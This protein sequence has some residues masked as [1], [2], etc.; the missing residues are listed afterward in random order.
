MGLHIVCLNILSQKAYHKFNTLFSHP[1][2][3][4]LFKVWM[5]A[6]NKIVGFNSI[7][8]ML[9]NLSGKRRI[10]RG[11]IIDLWTWCHAL[12]Q[13]FLWGTH[14]LSMYVTHSR[15]SA[16]LIYSSSHHSENSYGVSDLSNAAAA[17]CV[18]WRVS[19][20]SSFEHM[21]FSRIFGKSVYV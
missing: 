5:P 19:A 8:C 11:Q 4:V 2:N 17:R 16:Q 18:S 3:V 13:C 15:W 7:V 20:R 21:C 14:S 6:F 10:R 12:A 1:T 9:D